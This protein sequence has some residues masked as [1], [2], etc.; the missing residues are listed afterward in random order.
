MEL[1]ILIRDNT[2]SV[3]VCVCK[4]ERGYLRDK[5]TQRTCHY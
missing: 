1:F 3:F 2:E 4:R 5:D